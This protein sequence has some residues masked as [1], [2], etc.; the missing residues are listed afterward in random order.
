MDVHFT[1][2]LF[3]FFGLI[4]ADAKA[5][6]FPGGPLGSVGRRL[7]LRLIQVVFSDAAYGFL[8]RKNGYAFFWLGKI[9]FIMGKNTQKAMQ[10]WRNAAIRPPMASPRV[11]YSQG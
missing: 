1:G 10:H 8:W 9:S 11:L 6:L 4:L 5:A 3:D 7:P 2:F